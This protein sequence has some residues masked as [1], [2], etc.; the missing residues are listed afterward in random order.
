MSNR[1]ATAAD[2]V[3]G[4]NSIVV[5]VDTDLCNGRICLCHTKDWLLTGVRATSCR[6]GGSRLSCLGGLG[7]SSRCLGLLG[8]GGCDSPVLYFFKISG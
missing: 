2:F 5:R 4:S 6:S 3:D 8:E 7:Y 1:L